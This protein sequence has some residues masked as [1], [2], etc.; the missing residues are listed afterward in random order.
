MT[1]VGGARLEPNHQLPPCPF[2]C[3]LPVLLLLLDLLTVPL[4]LLLLIAGVVSPYAA[5]PAAVFA[6]P[7][8]SLDMPR[9]PP[10]PARGR[11]VAGMLLLARGDST[12]VVAEETTGV[13]LIGAFVVAAMSAE[14][15]AVSDALPS[16]LSAAVRKV[17]LQVRCVPL[18]GTCRAQQH[19]YQHDS[20]YCANVT[21]NSTKQETSQAKMQIL[22]LAKGTPQEVALVS[23]Q[24]RE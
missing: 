9:T 10:V 2:S 3:P 7:L 21:A 18:P 12:L 8:A 15:A 23:T 16:L 5:V 4:V 14:G 19:S 17:R 20:R 1:S 6:D 13:V 24:H 11:R 22:I